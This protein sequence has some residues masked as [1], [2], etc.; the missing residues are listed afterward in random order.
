MRWHLL[1]ALDKTLVHLEHWIRVL[2]VMR[3]LYADTTPQKLHVQLDYLRAS[4]LK[5]KQPDGHWHAKLDRLGIELLWSTPLIA[6]L[7]LP[8]QIS[9]GTEVTHGKSRQ[10]IC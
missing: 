4:W 5:L 9:T 3:A 8:V 1:N 10:L 2:D 6:K 7:V